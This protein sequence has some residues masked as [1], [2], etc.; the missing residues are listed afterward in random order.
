MLEFTSHYL[1]DHLT[2]KWNQTGS[3]YCL[4]FQPSPVL[5][6]TK[7]LGHLIPTALLFGQLL[8]KVSFCVFQSPGL[9]G[10]R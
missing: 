5:M 8:M 1:S 2:L 7:I 9:E 10:E 3:S 6:A 4:V